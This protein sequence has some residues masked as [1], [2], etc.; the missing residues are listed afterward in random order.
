MKKT[1]FKINY[2]AKYVKFFFVET[3]NFDEDYIYEYFLKNANSTHLGLEYE[4]HKI[5]YHSS[6]QSSF[7]RMGSFSTLS[8]ALAKYNFSINHSGALD[9]TPHKIETLK[10]QNS[11]Y[12]LSDISFQLMNNSNSV[13]SETNPVIN[14]SYYE[15]LQASYYTAGLGTTELSDVSF[16]LTPDFVE[17]VDSINEDENVLPFYTGG[18]INYFAVKYDGY[19]N[20]EQAGTY[21]ITLNSDDG[22][23]LWLNDTKIIDNDGLHGEESVSH[24]LFLNAG[25]HDLEVQYF[26]IAGGQ[27]IELYWTGPDSG[28]ITE[29]IGNDALQFLLGDI[30]GSNVSDT[31]NG[32]A[33]AEVILGFSGD[34]TINAGDGDDVLV[35]GSG[36]DIL[37]GENGADIFLFNSLANLS[38]VDTIQDF[39]LSENDTIDISSI[40]QNYDPLTDA[41]TNFVQITDDGTNSTL[42]LDID[43]GADSFTAIAIIANTTGLNNEEILVNDGHLII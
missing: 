17:V 15:G 30:L 11:Q 24:T 42:F 16:G 31:I 39:D 28:N 9:G 7:V 5:D 4:V 29:I 32:T 33:G 3:L 20:V 12:L 22:S 27:I 19:I 18:P 8:E 1:L 23:A 34:D 13:N 14:F 2:L 41:I 36:N 6:T 21:T 10:I 25:I 38:S 43:G 37:Y 40:L 35:G 26:E